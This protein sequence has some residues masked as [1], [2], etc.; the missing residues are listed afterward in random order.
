VGLAAPVGGRY[1][2]RMW[3]REQH[4]FCLWA[5]TVLI[6]VG[7]GTARAQPES[8]VT[9]QPVRIVPRCDP[10]S[11]GEILVCGDAERYRLPIRPDRFDP[12]GAVDSVSR[13][14]HR[15]MDEADQGVGTCSNI[16]PGGFSGCFH[17]DVKRR[18]KQETCGF[19]F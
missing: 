6:L 7:G 16:G 14:R 8:G 3:L 9:P 15:L 17:R 5:G 11:E 19:A 1:P 2:N 13:E 18:C 10:L 4:F 12:K